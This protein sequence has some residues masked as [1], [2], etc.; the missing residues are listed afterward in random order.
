LKL[1]AEGKLVP[2]GAY[3]KYDGGTTRLR[4]LGAVVNVAVVQVTVASRVFVCEG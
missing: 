3:V 2:D 4:A 1:K